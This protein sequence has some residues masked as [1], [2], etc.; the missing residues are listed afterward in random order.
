MGA[1][2]SSD[3]TYVWDIGSDASVNQY[4]A[5]NGQFI[6]TIIT[7]SPN[8]TVSS[9]GSN[10]W[11][12]NFVTGDVYKYNIASDTSDSFATV[13][14][15][16]FGV[17]SDGHSAWVASPD[18]SLCQINPSSY[19]ETY[20]PLEPGLF[21]VSSD[22]S[23]VWVGGSNYPDNYLYKVNATTGD[24][25]ASFNLGSYIPYSISSDRKNVW[26]VDNGI[27]EILQFNI[28]TDTSYSIPI[29]EMAN[30]INSDGTFVWVG[31]QT[32]ISPFSTIIKI[33][34]ATGQPIGSP[35]PIPSPNDTNNP[36]GISSD[37][38]FVWV[39]F[40][41][42]T[43]Y[44]YQIYPDADTPDGNRVTHTKGPQGT[45]SLYTPKIQVIPG[46]PTMPSPPHVYQLLKKGRV[47][48]TTYSYDFATHVFTFKNVDLSKPGTHEYVWYDATAQKTLY[49]FT[50][51]IGN[52][53][54]FGKGTDILCVHPLTGK[55]VYKKIEHLKEGDLVKTYKRGTK[56]IAE[57]I[58]GEF[59]NNP[60]V[61]HH[62]MY[63]MA[64]RPGMTG[65]LMVTGGHSILMDKTKMPAHV[66]KK[67]MGLLGGNI[68]VEDKYMWLA[69]ECP[70]FER[71]VD[72]ETY[73]YYHIALEH[74][75]DPTKKYGIW[76]NGVLTE[77]AS[78]KQIR[79]DPL[80]PIG[81][82]Q[83]QRQ[84][85]KMGISYR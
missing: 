48:S 57:I 69:S 5:T 77:T 21:C 7:E 61:W 45:V 71:I 49:R 56:R 1:S 46:T 72:N 22:G 32:G 29:Q 80:L 36:S 16:T 53:I 74:D 23:H 24:F 42:S 27:N 11:V 19:T 60:G 35:I 6:K 81:N 3:G 73:T 39:G 43:I 20:I 2:I 10:V 17:S 83:R 38:T 85:K 64:K 78:E 63:K 68:S 41:N 34:A 37:G 18:G 8:T 12:S 52:P 25:D 55:T 82:R 54:C 79:N 59:I 30:V 70:L 44:Q 4:D 67:Q 50:I 31:C 33:D 13:G 65:D 84:N 76:A 75:K 66:I 26:I 47:V 28:A 9:D 14:R 58:Q 15:S 40:G 51:Q 62:C